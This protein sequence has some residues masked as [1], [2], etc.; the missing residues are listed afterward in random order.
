[1]PKRSLNE[2]ID[3]FDRGESSDNIDDAPEVK[4]S[5]NKHAKSI[6]MVPIEATL[7]QALEKF[8]KE[9]KITVEKALGQILKT[10]ILKVA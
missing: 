1:M 7:L 4:F 9:K 5:I 8:A 6:R 10:T 3:A 2:I